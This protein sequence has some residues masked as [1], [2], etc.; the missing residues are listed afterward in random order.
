MRDTRKKAIRYLEENIAWDD[1]LTWKSLAVVCIGKCAIFC[2]YQF[3]IPIGVSNEIIAN[4]LSSFDKLIDSIDDERLSSMPYKDY[5]NSPEWKRKRRG[6]LDLKG[7]KCA[8]WGNTENLHIHHLTYERR[9]FETP[10]DLEVLCA[11][12]HRE[13]HFALDQT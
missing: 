13:V 5:L 10:N 1:W 2:L 4:L 3:Q 6:I 11:D 12:C 7:A 8:I 9:G